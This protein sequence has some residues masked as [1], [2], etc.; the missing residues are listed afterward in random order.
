MD[1]APDVIA[2]ERSGRL[3]GAGV[4]RIEFRASRGTAVARC[5]WIDPSGLPRITAASCA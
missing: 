2:Y 1:Y 5:V 4:S 3:A